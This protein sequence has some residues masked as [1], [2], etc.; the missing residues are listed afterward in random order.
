MNLTGNI[1]AGRE[2]NL[3]DACTLDISAGYRLPIGR[4]YV[5]VTNLLNAEVVSAG[6]Q[7]PESSYQ[8]EY[9]ELPRLARIGYEVSF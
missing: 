9:Y 2:D 1:L 8:Y 3:D 4:L 7:D 6:D 5:T